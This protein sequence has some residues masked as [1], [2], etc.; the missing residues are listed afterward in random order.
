MSIG[1]RKSQSF[2]AQTPEINM[3]RSAFDR[4]FTVKDTFNFDYLTPIFLDEVVPGDTINLNVQTLIRLQTQKVPLMDNMY[5]KFFFFYCPSRLLWDNFPKMMGERLNPGDTIDYTIP[6]IS[7]PDVGVIVGSLA[8]KLGF[9]INIGASLQSTNALPFRMYNKIWNDWFRSSEL[10]DQIVV[11]LDNGPDEYTDYVLKKINK[12]HDYFT[13]ALTDPQ[14]GTALSIPSASTIPIERVQGAAPQWFRYNSTTP[15]S[16]GSVSMSTDSGNTYLQDSSPNTIAMD[17]NGSLIGDMTG[18]MGTINELRTAFQLQALLERDNRGGT[19]YNEIVYSHFRVT[20]P[21]YRLQRTEYLGGGLININTSAVPNTGDDLAELGAF[22]TATAANTHIGFTHSFV[23]H[24]YVIGMVVCT[25]DITYQQ[26]IN[27]LWSRQT[28]YDFFWPELQQLGE[29][30]ILNKEIYYDGT[31]NDD[32]VWAYA[33]RYAEYKFKPSEIHG[34]FRSQYA[35]PLD[36]W[37]L[38]EEFSALPNFNSDFLE[39]NTPIERAITVTTQDQ[40]KAD[41]FFQ[42]KHTRPMMAR[43]IPASLGRMY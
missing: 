25:A 13:S 19:R 7:L 12:K 9:N 17:P 37:H 35:T 24:G 30:A 15:S 27:K 39:S 2:F 36:M 14:K 4:S 5:A 1:S 29:Q 6:Q 41:Y 34:E 21:D 8:E 26:G 16:T 43:P 33:E 10:Q 23:E 3:P 32:E 28:R 42:Y 11:D 38:A 18:I 31:S 20:I 40:L 22:A